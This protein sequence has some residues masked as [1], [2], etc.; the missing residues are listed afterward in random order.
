ML[1][2]LF[3][4][5]AIYGLSPQIIKIANFFALPIITK[6][7]TA[8]DYG[9]SGVMTAY[10]MATSVLAGLGLRVVLVNSF[11]KSPGQYKWL[12]RQS[13]GFLIMWNWLYAI[14]L[15]V[16]IY[17]VTPLEALDNRLTILLLNVLPIVFFGPTKTI[18]T[19]YYQI[20]EMPL[21]IA[22]RTGIF[23]LSTV[24]LNIYF[25]SILK[26]GYMGWFW[27][28]FIV[29]VIT[30]IS[31]YYPLNFKLKMSPIFNF[32]RRLIRNCLKI[33]LPTVPHYYSS[34]LLNSSDRLVMDMLKVDTSYIG[35]YN[36]AYTVSGIMGSLGNAS[37]LAI[38][39]LLNRMY[40]NGHDEKGKWLVF[41][42]Q[43]I[44][45][46]LSFS[47]CVWM[48]E[49][50]ELLIKNNEL[51][52]MYPLGIVIV[53]AYNY[54]PMYLGANAKLIFSEKTNVLWKVT[55]IAGLINV[56]LNFIFI[57]IYGFQVAAYTTFISLMF[58][59]YSGFFYRVFREISNVKYYP[60][61][62]L[63]INIILTILAY[64][65]VEYHIVHK[66]I[67]TSILLCLS[68]LSLYLVNRKINGFQHS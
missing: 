28:N 63:F 5:T 48:K 27:S 66:M 56:L 29:G 64:F 44:F 6:D 43:I 59:G 1:R 18:A 34:Y 45:F 30:N 58:M 68:L 15:S 17:Y 53:M 23:G 22:I 12:W 40:K 55:L 42:L 10:T 36:V 9:V 65:A 7:L 61:I 46:A 47:M 52:Q 54:R 35:K 26:M 11:Y 51:A 20:N 16:L 33:S 8:L 24:F 25:I 21:Q 67:I 3:S 38:V 13:Y 2:K 14:L 4:H 31:Y 19:T 32:K 62:W 41:A 50:F 57:P 39:P 60:L 37:G 49:I